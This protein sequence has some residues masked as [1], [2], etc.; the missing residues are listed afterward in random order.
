MTVS[1]PGNAVPFLQ[2]AAVGLDTHTHKP[3]SKQKS[4]KNTVK[5]L[6]HSETSNIL[7]QGD[8]LDISVGRI[9]DLEINTS[10]KSITETKTRNSPFFDKL[11]TL[12]KTE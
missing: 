3:K 12:M 8:L 5:D 6:H 4:Q 1:R 2:L 9:S 7:N 10:N 11:K